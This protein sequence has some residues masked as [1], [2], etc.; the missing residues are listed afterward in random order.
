MPNPDALTAEEVAA[1]LRVGKGSVYRLARTGALPSYH[2]GRKLR[3]T[4]RDVSAYMTAARQGAK[5]PSRPQESGVPSPSKAFPLDDR[6]SFLV[7]GGGL[8]G[9]SSPR[10]SASWGF[11]S[12]MPGRTAIRRS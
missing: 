2:V 6:D 4:A 9:A 8:E 1:L 3:F 5:A 12:P 10:C 11:R 7:A